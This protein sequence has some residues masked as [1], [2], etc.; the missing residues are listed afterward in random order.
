M[1]LKNQDL[2]RSNFEK[3]L[4]PIEVATITEYKDSDALCPFKSAGF[5]GEIGLVDYTPTSNN[6]SSR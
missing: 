4:N 5:A 1:G 3:G 6:G 2:F